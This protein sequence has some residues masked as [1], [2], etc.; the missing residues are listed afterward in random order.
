[1]VHGRQMSHVGG[2]QPTKL[3]APYPATGTQE[4]TQ[5]PVVGRLCV[6]RVSHCLCPRDEQIPR[7]ESVV[8]ERHTAANAWRVLPLCLVAPKV[9][10]Q[11]VAGARIPATWHELLRELV[12]LHIA[13]EPDDGKLN[14]V[15]LGDHERRLHPDHF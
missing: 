12:E 11:S 9:E 8:E 5:Y 2:G 10:E 7:R 3:R 14:S 4:L 13:V 15:H 6:Q 1:M